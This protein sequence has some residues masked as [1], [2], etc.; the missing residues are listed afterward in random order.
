MLRA[1]FAVSVLLFAA[2]AS[3]AITEAGLVGTWEASAPY[4]IQIHGKSTTTYRAD[5]T[6]THREYG[7]YA[8]TGH[9]T[10]SLRGRELVTRFGKKLVVRS[11]SQRHS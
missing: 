11:V 10:W 3:A 2:S 8:T 9:G 5:H 4:M 1:Y 6:C 7:D